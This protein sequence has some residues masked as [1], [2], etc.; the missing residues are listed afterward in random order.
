VNPQLIVDTRGLSCPMPV[1][2]TSDALKQLD[3]GALLEVVSDD[4]AIEL[5]LPAWCKSNGHTI[6]HREKRAGAF[7]FIVEK[8]GAP[9]GESDGK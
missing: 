3:S 7:R 6:R 9:G 4:P 1:I 8:G 2:K 5:D